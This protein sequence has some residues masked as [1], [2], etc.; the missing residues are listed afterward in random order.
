[1]HGFVKAATVA[2]L[3]GLA[4]FHANDV[5]TVAA[6][7]TGLFSSAIG[8][9]GGSSGTAKTTGKGAA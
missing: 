8:L 3:L 6:K 2:G 1:M 9:A 7:T 5:A 4:I